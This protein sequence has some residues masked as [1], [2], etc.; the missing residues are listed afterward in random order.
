MTI[1]QHFC[2]VWEV[3]TMNTCQKKPTWFLGVRGEAVL[4]TEPKALHMLKN[5]L[6]DLSHALA[7][8]FRQCTRPPAQEY[9]PSSSHS[10]HRERTA[11]LNIPSHRQHAFLWLN[12]IHSYFKSQKH[13]STKRP[14]IKAY[15]KTLEPGDFGGRLSAPLGSW[16]IVNSHSNMPGLVWL[17]AYI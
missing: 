15:S 12:I 14:N 1:L 8:D 2:F 3:A 13:N 5:V 4:G 7:Y 10:L 11:L 6:Y 17:T 16:E 9:R